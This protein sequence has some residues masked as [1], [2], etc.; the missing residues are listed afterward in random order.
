MDWSK[1]TFSYTKTNTLLCRYFRVW[2][3]GQPINP[4][5]LEG[6]GSGEIQKVKDKAGFERAKASYLAEVDSIGAVNIAKQ[7]FETL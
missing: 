3:N 4:L 7:L 1:L 2:K 6:A 5:K